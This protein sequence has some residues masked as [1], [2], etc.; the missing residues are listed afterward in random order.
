[1]NKC[2][3]VRKIIQ[4]TIVVSCMYSSNSQVAKCAGYSHLQRLTVVCRIDFSTVCYAMSAVLFCHTVAAYFRHAHFLFTK[5]VT[6]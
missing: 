5:T 6:H 2:M 4:I 1:M 3:G